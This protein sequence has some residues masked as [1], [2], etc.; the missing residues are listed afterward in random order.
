MHNPE[1]KT[2]RTKNRKSKI[3]SYIVK[4]NDNQSIDDIFKV[5]QKVYHATFGKGE[6]KGLEGQGDKMKI[7]VIFTDE[8][9]TKKLMIS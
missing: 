5:G 8:G 6:V 4:N 3:N 9:I 2:I 7:T 1:E